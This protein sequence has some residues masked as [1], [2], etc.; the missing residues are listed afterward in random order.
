MKINFTGLLGIIL[1]ISSIGNLLAQCPTT[2]LPTTTVKGKFEINSNN[3]KTITEGVNNTKVTVC[4]NSGFIVTDKSG[5][6]GVQYYF[7]TTRTAFPNPP[8]GYLAGG[9]RTL[10]TAGAG[11]YI[12]IQVSYD[13]TTRAIKSYACQAVEVKTPQPS[14]KFLLSSCT[15]LQAQLDIP[16][17]ANNTFDSYLINWGD[18]TASETVLKAQIPLLAKKHTFPNINNRTITITGKKTSEVCDATVTSQIIP[19]GKSTYIPTLVSL[20]VQDNDTTQIRYVG[21]NYSFDFFQKTPTD[22]F[23]KT[24]TIVNP[25]VAFNT[26]KLPVKNSDKDQYC[27]KIGVTDACARTNFSDSSCTIPLQVNVLDKRNFLKWKTLTYPRFVSYRISKNGNANFKTITK[28]TTDTL[29]DRPTVCGTNYTYQV[30]GLSGAIQT[31]SR[32][33]SVIGVDSTKPPSITNVLVSVEKDKVS[34]TA[35]IPAGQRLKNYIF[36]RYNSNKLEQ[37]YVGNGTRTFDDKSEPSKQRECY[38]V[39]FENNCGIKS[40]TSTTFC[41]SFLTLE[42]VGFK[43]TDYQKF[44]LGLNAYFVEKLDDKGAVLS[45]TKVDKNLKFEPDPTTIDPANPIVRFRVR[46]LSTNNL[47]S[48]SNEVLYAQKLLLFIPDAFSPNGDNINEVFGVKGIFIKDF[49]MRIS[50]R[51]GDVL[52]ETQDYKVG[53]DGSYNGEVVPVGQYFYEV[54]ATDYRGETTKKIGRLMVVR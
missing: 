8:N 34:I 15:T 24:K 29:T 9:T 53:W 14:P 43:W 23:Q 11:Q 51:M 12:V 18:G 31:L 28:S 6:A 54:S 39:A 21:G 41:P 13:A 36:Y 46:A 16:T 32:S 5:L 22:I 1:F 48:Y 30:I 10:P 50:N 25:A 17:D 40:D 37:F 33:I 20:A 2:G 42:G 52:F 35:T 44:P 45:T 38:K 3:I 49:I 27:Y 4:P 26:L 47:V 19:N 7:N